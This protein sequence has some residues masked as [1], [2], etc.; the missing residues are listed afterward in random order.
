[1]HLRL[2]SMIVLI[3]VENL[4]PSVLSTLEI[5]VIDDHGKINLMGLEYLPIFMSGHELVEY[6]ITLICW[7]LTS[8]PS[9]RSVYRDTP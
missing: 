3:Q 6:C 7:L 1:M 4:F 8:L 2:S 9:N 5:I